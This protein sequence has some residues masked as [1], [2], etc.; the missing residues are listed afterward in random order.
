MKESYPLFKNKKLLFEYNQNTKLKD[1]QIS[2][3]FKGF[4]YS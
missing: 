3:T 1:L 2:S 4:F